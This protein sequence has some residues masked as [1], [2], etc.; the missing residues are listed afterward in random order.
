MG[1]NKVD[2]YKQKYGYSSTTGCFIFFI[3]VAI[4]VYFGWKI[5]FGSSSTSS[6]I[7]NEKP[8]EVTLMT[9][10]QMILDGYL[11]SPKY[12]S[13]KGDYTFVETGLR[14]KIEGNVKENGINQRFYLIIEF[15]N[16]NYNE[17]KIISLQ[18]GNSRI[19]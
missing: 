9:Y 11:N 2:D 7:K 18:V 3:L 1:N 19:L 17:Y 5:L 4:I 15:D 12:S 6:N 8:D 13:Y 10:A 16:T 14:Y